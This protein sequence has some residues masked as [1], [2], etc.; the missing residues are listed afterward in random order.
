MPL[1]RSRNEYFI[2]LFFSMAM[3]SRCSCFFRAMTVLGAENQL[4][5]STYFAL[6]PA[7][8]AEC[9]S[10][11]MTSVALRLAWSLLLPA[12]ERPLQRAAS[13]S[14]FLSSAAERQAVNALNEKLNSICKVKETLIKAF[15]APDLRRKAADSTVNPCASAGG[16]KE[17]LI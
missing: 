1:I 11:T 17:I 9:T 8:C 7:H 4:S 2:L 5:D 3:V 6:M 12:R 13:H 14:R 10:S 15:P 16:A